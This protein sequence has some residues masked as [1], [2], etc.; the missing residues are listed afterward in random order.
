MPLASD[1][2]Q[3]FTS[4]FSLYTWVTVATAAG[5]FA[6]GLFAAW[7]SRPRPG[8]KPSARHEANAVELVYALVLVGVIAL[9][10][11]RT[12]TTENRVDATASNG[13]ERAPAAAGQSG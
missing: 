6:G 1:T 13:N 8:R 3:E 12:F 9:L 2:R 4:L 10:V 5:I 11:T 7:H